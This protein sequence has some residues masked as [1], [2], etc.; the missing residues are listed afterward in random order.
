MYVVASTGGPTAL[1]GLIRQVEIGFINLVDLAGKDSLRICELMRRY[2]DV[3]M[4]FADG[5]LVVAA[6]IL[7]AT[8]LLTFGGH[9]FAYKINEKTPFVVLPA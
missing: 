1:T 5:S 7:N 4:D 8:N 3:P 6:E 2:S 9:F